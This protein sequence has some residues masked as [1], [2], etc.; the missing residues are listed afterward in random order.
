MSIIALMVLLNPST[1]VGLVRNFVAPELRQNSRSDLEEEVERIATGMCLKSSDNFI[2]LK[3]SRPCILGKFKSSR[4]ML[5]KSLHTLRK[6]MFFNHSS[7]TE[8]YTLTP[9]AALP[10]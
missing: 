4:M 6:G 3:I 1:V 7:T 10:I 5:G 2:R 8:I 9:H